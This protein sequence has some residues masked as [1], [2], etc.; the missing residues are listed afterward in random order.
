L[1][2]D[3]DYSKGLKVMSRRYGGGRTTCESCKSIDVRIWHRTGRL[4]PG[5]YF[6]WCWTWRGEPSGNINVRTEWDAVVLLYRVRSLGGTEWKSI[7]QRVPITWTSCHLGGQRPW[8]TCAVLVNCS[9][10]GAVMGSP[11]RASR[12]CLGIEA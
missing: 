6:S 4:C 12:S 10:A 8:F 11:M 7:E 2:N 9:P 1:P 3:F 5:Q